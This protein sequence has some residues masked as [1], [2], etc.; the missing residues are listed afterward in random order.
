MVW[1]DLEDASI[2]HRAGNNIAKSF[3]HDVIG[4][5]GSILTCAEEW[6]ELTIA[7]SV[8]SRV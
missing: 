8:L 2:I 1:C 5:V 7:C 4:S 6:A 3:S